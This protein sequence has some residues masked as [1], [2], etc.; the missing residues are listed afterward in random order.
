[1]NDVN[2][3]VTFHS[4]DTAFNKGPKGHEAVMT[5]AQNE[6]EAAT[7]D[8]VEAAMLMAGL[9][10]AMKSIEE[11][12]HTRGVLV[13]P[14]NRM[15]SLLQSFIADKA[16]EFETLPTGGE[17]AKFDE[18][19][20]LGWFFSLFTWIKG[21]KKHAWLDAPAE[22]K[23]FGQSARLALLGDWGTGLYGAPACADSIKSDPRGYDLLF[24]LGDVYY[25]G[26]T[27]EIQNR[28]LK[29]WPRN[30]TT[31]RNAVSRA[32]NSN[33][34]MYT[35]ANAYFDST[36]TAFNQSASY[37]AMQNEHWLLVGLDSAYN[38][39]DVMHNKADLNEPQV[40]WLDN[41]IAQAG[42]RKVILFSHHQP[43]SHFDGQ[44]QMMT[45]RLAG[46]LASR[47]IFAWYWGHEHR[48]ILFDQHPTWG[49]FG[50]C[51]GHSG[52]PYFRDKLQNAPIVEHKPLDTK[53]HRLDAKNMLPGAII[54]DGPNPYLTG[55]ESKYGVQGY[56]SLEFDGP[57]LNEVVHAPDRTV[58]YDRSL[59]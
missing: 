22:P 2:P 30:E 49:F 59:V 37:F 14:D 46:H 15:A 39:P 48:S 41:I 47:K 57:H 23:T 43:F 38:T 53:W 35:G 45:G 33:H 19:D 40:A 27:K 9:G 32:C 11:H 26:D 42:T 54:L 6:A 56:M 36:L 12:E 1:M 8:P 13:S 55:E 44:N 50:R 10:E 52:F 28:F 58:L 29:F 5:T 25:A 51:A 3:I 34:E 16:N 20:I 24:H 4:I 18:R 7:G 21:M 31:L 17:E